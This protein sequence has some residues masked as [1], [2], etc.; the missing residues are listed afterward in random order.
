MKYFKCGREGNADNPHTHT[1]GTTYLKRAY[2]PSVEH[3]ACILKT[4]QRI[5]KEDFNLREMFPKL[6]R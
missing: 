5:L 1:S 2:W 6:I 3:P 4:E